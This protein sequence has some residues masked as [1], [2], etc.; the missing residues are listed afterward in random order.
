MKFLHSSSVIALILMTFFYFAMCPFIYFRHDD[1]LMLGNAV[2]ILPKDWAFLWKPT[3]FTSPQHEEVW[4]F[5]PFFKYIIWV[6]YELFSFN[7]FLWTLTHWIFLVSGILLGGKAL[8][9]LTQETKRSELFKTIIVCSLSIHFASVVW[10]GEGMMNTPQVFLL[11]FSTYLFA[12]ESAGASLLS[13]L[14][15]FL[16]LGF[17]ESSVFLPLFLFAIA[18][19]LNIFQKKKNLLL[20]HFGLMILFLIFRLGLLPFNPGYKPHFSTSTLLRPIFYFVGFLSLPLL[21]L[22]LSHP[23]KGFITHLFFRRL[24]FFLPFL[25]LLV[26]PHLGHSFFSPGWLLLPGFFSIWVLIF[27]LDT[28]EIKIIS[29]QKWGLISLV[30]SALPVFYQVHRIQWLDWSGSQKKVHHYLRDLPDSTTGIYIET[31]SDPGHPEV[32]FQR[33]VG[34]QENLEHMWNLHHPSLVPIRL[35]ACGKRPEASQLPAGSVVARWK[36]PDFE[37]NL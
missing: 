36:F 2:S 3:W 13:V 33:V 1:W 5:R 21:S 6:G 28:S 32:S 29:I 8:D 7:S 23:K 17:K 37:E 34:A 15:Y 18:F 4:F 30:L 9:L 12:Q 35:I 31:C 14:V 26:A 11:M 27:C 20:A 25:G 16:A 10:V 19:S 22:V 24:L